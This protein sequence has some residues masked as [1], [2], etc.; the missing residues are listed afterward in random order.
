[1]KYR[2]IA[3]FLVLLGMS[4]IAL[5]LTIGGAAASSSAGNS[6][7]YVLHGTPNPNATAEPRDDDHD[8]VDSN[9]IPTYYRDIEPILQ[10]ECISCHVAGEIGYAVFEMDDPMKII[11]GDNPDYIA[12][13]TDIGY[14]PPWHATGESPKML[15]ERTLTDLEI[16]LISAWAE[17]GAPLGDSTD[18]PETVATPSVQHIRTDVVLPMTEA[19]AVDT[20]LDDDYRCFILEPDFAEDMYITGSSV[21]PGNR[22][23]AHHAL[24]YVVSEDMRASAYA[25]D[26]AD[27]GPGYQCFGG[28]NLQTGDPMNSVVDGRQLLQAL[29]NQGFSIMDLVDALAVGSIEEL[30][31]KPWDD[32]QNALIEAG[33]DMDRLFEDAGVRNLNGLENPTSVN[34]LV[35]AWVPG[36]VATVYPQNTGLYAPANSFLVMQMH[37]NTAAGAGSDV[38]TVNLQVEPYSDTITGIEGRPLVAPV[39]IPCPEGVDNPACERSVAQAQVENP[40]TSDALLAACGQSLE[41]YAD[42]TADNAYGY[43]DYTVGNSGWV[44]QVGGHMHELGRNM[45]ITLNPDTDNATVLLDIPQ[46]D[47]D[48]QGTYFLADPVAVERGDTLRV[49][50][51]WDNTDG[52]RYVVWGEGTADEMCWNPVNYIP[53]EEGRTLADYGYEE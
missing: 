12:F 15:Q 50:C 21:V 13:V 45:R 48:W 53:R 22:E 9:Y 4:I 11:D 8:H 40:R 43:C 14:M 25:L 1:M 47:F 23:L 44:F 38:S 33:V 28:T 31:D 7:E 6:M 26:A 29:Q 34:R 46:W 2:W 10:A 41:T 49:E 51:W 42:N 39:E 16:A 18:S 27:E 3:S 30:R 20:S 37:Y 52:E 35:A 19:Y 17:A 32:I 24:I 36:M 5:G